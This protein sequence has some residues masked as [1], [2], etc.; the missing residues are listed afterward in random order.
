[1]P[2]SPSALTCQNRHGSLC[3]VDTLSAG[4][5]SDMASNK[6]QGFNVYLGTLPEKEQAL[7]NLSAIATA[8][9]IDSAGKMIRWLATQEPSAI[10]EALKPIRRVEVSEKLSELS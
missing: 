10:I 3:L 8:L 2:V 9:E 4:I 6:T 5:E 1:M 7:A